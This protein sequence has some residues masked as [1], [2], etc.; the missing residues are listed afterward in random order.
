MKVL[1][2]GRLIHD[3]NILV[4]QYP[5]EASEIVT[6]ELVSCS[7][8]STCMVAYTLAKWNEESYISGVLGYDDTGNAMRKDMES[9]RVLT[10]FLETNYDIKTPTTY[11]ITNKQ[12]NSKTSIQAEVDDFHIKKYEYDQPMDCVV[13]DGYEYNAAVY[14]Y[15]KY[16]SNITILNAKTP[17]QNLLDF[18]KYAKYIVASGEVIEAMLGTKIDTNNPMA[19]SNIYKKV[20]DKYPHIYLLIVIDGY[21]TIYQLNGEIKI[22][23]DIKNEG[24]DK[25]GSFDV[26]VSGIAY[27]LIHHY[28]METTIRLAT[29]AKSLAKNAL[30]STLSIPLLSDVLA[31]Y[32]SRF[33]K[34][35]DSSMPNNPGGNNA[36]VQP[37]QPSSPQP[38]MQPAPNPQPPVNPE[39]TPSSQ[40]EGSTTNN[41]PTSK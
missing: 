19:L 38:N 30:G 25:T 24:I 20:M 36:N 34:I 35:V 28:D 16:S 7:G 5:T 22:L 31:D 41:A 17:H 13:A 15:N 32:E 4:D 39:P 29:I 26:F 11:I 18:F 9:N 14:A 37:N 2:I 33:G 27:G 3:V 21:G 6:K 8:G 10:A 1:S 40:P 23:A 12:N